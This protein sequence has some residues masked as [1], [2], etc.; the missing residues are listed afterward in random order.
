[1]KRIIFIG[2]H[3]KKGMKPLDSKTMTGKVIDSIIIGLNNSNCI[4][5]NLCECEYM[6]VDKQEIQEWNNVWHQKYEP[7]TKDV[8]VT[9]GTW[10]H[11]NFDQRSISVVKLGHPAGQYGT[12]KKLEYINNAILKIN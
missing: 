6:P 7:T 2:M 4:K 1:M 5:T 3:N 12:S 9:L 11:E 8:V 10:V